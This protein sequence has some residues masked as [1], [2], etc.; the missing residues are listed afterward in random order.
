MIA[1]NCAVLLQE[2]AEVSASGFALFIWFTTGSFFKDVLYVQNG[3]PLP[4]AIVGILF[5]YACFLAIKRLV[6][7]PHFAGTME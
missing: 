1:G 3:G 4:G 5:A 2:A 7:K 6:I